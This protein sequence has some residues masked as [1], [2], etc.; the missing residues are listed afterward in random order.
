MAEGGSEGEGLNNCTRTVLIFIFLNGFFFLCCA[1]L[2]I[3]ITGLWFFFFLNLF[4]GPV[5]FHLPFGLAKCDV[6]YVR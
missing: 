5:A 3:T 4:L 2:W 1:S 6:V